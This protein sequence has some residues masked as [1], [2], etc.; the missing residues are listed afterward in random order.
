MNA[1]ELIELFRKQFDSNGPIV[2]NWIICEAWNKNFNANIENLLSK[3]DIEA[4]RRIVRKIEK[5]QKK[6]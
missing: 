3:S 6:R 4:L 5:N 1:K 2:Y